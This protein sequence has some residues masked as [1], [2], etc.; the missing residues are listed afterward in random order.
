MKNIK[1]TTKSQFNSHW[2]YITMYVFN[3]LF[4]SDSHILLGLSIDLFFMLNK[5]T[6]VF[7]I[8][9]NINGF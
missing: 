7:T 1:I 4:E 9:F 6:I 3:I 5:I 2:W 8:I